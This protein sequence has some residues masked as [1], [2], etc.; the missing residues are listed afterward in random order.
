M[1]NKIYKEDINKILVIAITGIGENILLIPFL[2]ELSLTWPKASIDLCLRFDESISLLRPL[3]F[4]RNFIVCDY[5]RQNT[6]KKKIKLIN[7]LRKEK[8]DVCF[9][10]FPSDR[11]DKLLLAGLSGAKNIVAH[12]PTGLRKIM[13][14]PR[15]VDIKVDKEL[16]D[17]RQNLNL[18]LPF[19]QDIDQITPTIKLQASALAL[20]KAEDF[21]QRHNLKKEDTIVAIHAGSSKAFNMHYKRWPADRYGELAS[22]LIDKFK[23]KIFNFRT[24][25]DPPIIVAGGMKHNFINVEE[26][27]DVA[28]ALLSFCKLFI[29]ND[30]ALMHLA[31]A[32]GIKVIGIFGPTDPKRTKPYTE[33]AAVVQSE[34]KCAPCFNFSRIGKGLVCAYKTPECFKDITVSQMLSV[35]EKL[36]FKEQ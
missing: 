23:V 35:S 21:I 31:A 28:L 8:Y 6:L 30:A 20:R 26:P 12:Q 15:Q 2:K 27:L 18:L 3:G 7:N 34:I 29:G 33:K 22:R 14:P 9:L 36:A 16:H 17:V 11:F 1:S 32:S 25:E 24:K 10:T 4:I 19:R 5:N 13:S